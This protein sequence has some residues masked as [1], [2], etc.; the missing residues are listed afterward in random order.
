MPTSAENLQTAYE[1]V[2]QQ[3]ADMTANPKPSYSSAGRSISWG[4]HYRNLLE[5]R[6]EILLALQQDSGPFQ[7]TSWGV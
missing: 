7:V 4:E 6:K 5:S 1:N 2:C 3:L